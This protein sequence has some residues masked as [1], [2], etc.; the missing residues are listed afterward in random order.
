MTRSHLYSLSIINKRGKND[1]A[2]DQ[3]KYEKHKLFGTGS[4]G[5]D[6]N[7]QPR[8]MSGEFEESENP[9]YGEKLQNICI[10]QVGGHLLKDQVN[11]EAHGCH[12]INYVDTRSIGRKLSVYR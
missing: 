8:G 6:Q 2:Q 5:L 1:N 9:D 4:E 10:F 12:V 3:E 11:V 7:F